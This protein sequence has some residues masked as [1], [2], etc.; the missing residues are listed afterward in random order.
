MYVLES[1]FDVIILFHSAELAKSEMFAGTFDIWT[2]IKQVHFLKCLGFAFSTIRLRSRCHDTVLIFLEVKC[3]RASRD[4][5]ALAFRASHHQIVSR[6]LHETLVV[7]ANL[8]VLTFQLLNAVMFF[9]AVGFVRK[10]TVLAVDDEIWADLLVLIYIAKFD[11]DA[12]AERALVFA[13]EALLQMLHGCL[14][15]KT[16][17]VSFFRFLPA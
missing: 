15:I 4:N 10:L 3:H 7:F 2:N 6:L 8:S 14:I 16:L 11:H 5:K 1:F 13:V 9:A 12:T 17:L